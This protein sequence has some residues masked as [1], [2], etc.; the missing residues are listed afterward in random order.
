VRI[1]RAGS[2]D[3]PR[4]D[5]KNGLLNYPQ[6]RR[7][8]DPVRFFVPCDAVVAMTIRRFKESSARSWPY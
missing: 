7:A 8:G 6:L 2:T 4:F 1:I 5:I 3:F